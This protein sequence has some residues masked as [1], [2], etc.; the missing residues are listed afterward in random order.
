MS[1]NNP[2]CFPACCLFYPT[3]GCH[4]NSHWT[5][6]SSQVWKFLYKR[7][8]CSDKLLRVSHTPKRFFSSIAINRKMAVL[9]Q[10]HCEFIYKC[11][12]SYK[13]NTEISCMF[14]Y[15][16]RMISWKSGKSYNELKKSCVCICVMQKWI[17][18][19]PFHPAPLNCL[20]EQF[21]FL[22]LYCTFSETDI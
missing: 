5:W 18:L 11:F 10:I 3:P 1:Y 17:N 19:G 6:C 4:W 9:C 8:P 20:F 22:I 15:C 21:M 14:T 16:K 2:S 7:M 12:K 13:S